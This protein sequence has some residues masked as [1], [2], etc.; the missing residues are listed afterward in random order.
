MSETTTVAIPPGVTWRFFAPVAVDL[1]G[2]DGT[3]VGVA[4]VEQEG[5]QLALT[6]IQGWRV[7][8]PVGTRY[9]DQHGNEVRREGV[10]VCPCG[11]KYWEHDRC[12]DCGGSDPLV[13]EDDRYG[14]LS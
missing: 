11:C 1:V 12:I 3:T 9:A 5:H 13:P 14:L 4:S 7:R 8:F 10:D 2:P 6:G